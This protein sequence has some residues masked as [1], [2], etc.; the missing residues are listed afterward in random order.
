MRH[1]LF[2]D[3]DGTLLDHEGYSWEEARPAL[4][5]LEDLGIPIIM[6]TS[7]TR[8][9]VEV[10]QREMDLEEP[11]V[12]ENGGGVFF[13]DSHLDL[14]I[15]DSTMVSPYRMVTL[16]VPYSEVRR[17]IEDRQGRFDIEGFGDMGA[18]RIAEL[19]GLPPAQARLAERRDFTE[20]FL[21]ADPEQ[22]ATLVQEAASAGL[23]VTTGGRFHHLIGARQDKGRA[24]D[25][26]TEIFRR[27]WGG[28]METIALGDSPND[29]PMLERVDHPIVIPRPAGP[30]LQLQNRR[31]RV[32]KHRGSRGWGE[33]VRELIEPL[34]S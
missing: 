29:L 18:A 3:L 34:Y 16:G 15:P 10:L 13:P 7:K 20:P 1:L 14:E 19:T 25:V 26:V 23:A 22:L 12:V 30:P 9:E 32:A 4:E 27:H 11:F 6:V 24:V 17:F 33:A 8:A 21:I 28:E 31:G 5:R 2:T